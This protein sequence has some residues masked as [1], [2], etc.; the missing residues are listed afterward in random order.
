MFFTLIRHIEKNHAHM[1]EFP[2][3]FILINILIESPGKKKIFI[4]TVIPSNRIT[5]AAHRIK[6]L[7]IKMLV[8]F[9]HFHLCPSL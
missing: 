3:F 6:T 4:I 1:I 9:V 5:S 2:F 7:K 8:F